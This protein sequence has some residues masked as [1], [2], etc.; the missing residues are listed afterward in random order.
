MIEHHARRLPPSGI[1]SLRGFR[2]KSWE[3]CVR[4]D[5]GTQKYNG[6]EIGF[7]QRVKGGASMMAAGERRKGWRTV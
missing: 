1:G 2:F 6:K 5:I 3:V 7:T 4:R